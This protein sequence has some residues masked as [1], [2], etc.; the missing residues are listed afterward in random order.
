MSSDPEEDFEFVNVTEVYKVP[1][2]YR[3]K[4][5]R[6]CWLRLSRHRFRWIGLSEISLFRRRRRYLHTCDTCGRNTWRSA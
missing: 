4:L 2:A 1:R 3:L 6:H 5:P